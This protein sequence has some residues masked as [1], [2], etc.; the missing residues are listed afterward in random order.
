MPTAT[1]SRE[2]LTSQKPSALPLDQVRA[3]R[4]RRVEMQ[5]FL[6]QVVKGVK[7][8]MRAGSTGG[9]WGVNYCYAKELGMSL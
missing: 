1:M 6:F 9:S 8:L 5:V 4:E 7:Y 3:A 2:D